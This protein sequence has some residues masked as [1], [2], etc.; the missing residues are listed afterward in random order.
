MYKRK[1]NELALK[2]QLEVKRKTKNRELDEPHHEGKNPKF[3]VM[4][5][6][7]L[8]EVVE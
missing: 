1:I 3:S 7:E 6:Q 5:Q 4:T 8:L 2:I